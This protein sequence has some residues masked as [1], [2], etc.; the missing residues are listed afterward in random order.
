MA[1]DYKRI[2]KHL[3]IRDKKAS[4]FENED[5]TN[6]IKYL[7]RKNNFESALELINSSQK[8]YPN[9]M[10]IKTYKAMTL[11]KMHKNEESLKTFEEI[12]NRNDLNDRVRVFAMTGYANVLSIIQR[13]DDAIYYF[14]KILSESNDL[15]LVVRSK[16]SSLYT[17]QGRFNDAINILT[18]DGFNNQY[19]NVKRAC[20]YCDEGKFR[21]ALNELD[22]EEENITNITLK[23]KF[24]DKYTLQEMDYIR[25]HAY[26]KLDEM[27]N[28]LKYLQNAVVVK[29][30]SV[31]YKIN[32]DIIKIYILKAQIDDAIS[33]CEELKKGCTSDFYNKTIDKL[34]AKAYLRKNDYARASEH[35]N[36]AYCSEE[37]K[38]LNLGSL[39]LVR[40]NFKKAE[41]YFSILD[42]E[43]YPVSEKYE[44]Y[45]KYSLVKLRLKKYDETLEILKKLEENID[46]YEIRQMSYEIKRIELYVKVQKGEEKDELIDTYSKRQIVY[47]NKKDAINHVLDHHYY[48][49]KTS[50][51]NNSDIVEELFDNIDNLIDEKKAI[52]ENLLDKYIIKYPNVGINMN[53][54][55]INQLTILTLPN[56]KNVVTMYPCDGTESIF[57]LEELEE[58]PKPKV[59]RLTQ[60]EKF[61]K[62]YNL[63]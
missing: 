28:A 63:K 24:D 37:E 56:T 31:Y 29:N 52:Y 30:K 13:E 2:K 9:D 5:I 27:D 47:Y 33:L 26:F 12:L 16:L 18:I 57:T 17:K 23:E 54:D 3:E 22:R 1:H 4:N 7:L 55:T 59:K 53:G 42:E 48:N 34:L 60:S 14:E 44:I 19:L 50:K 61:Y 8:N 6:K 36:N 49:V 39:E 45:Y 35:Y 41:E 46:K 11:F 38:K 25:G 62:K 43:K 58:M 21:K 15:Q 20:V 32:F 51:F 10:Y 40:G